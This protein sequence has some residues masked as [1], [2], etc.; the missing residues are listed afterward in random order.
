MNVMGWCAE[1]KVTGQRVN[2]QS[3][4]RLRDELFELI[5]GNNCEWKSENKDKKRI[6]FIFGEKWKDTRVKVDGYE[7]N[8]LRMLTGCEST[9][10]GCNDGEYVVIFSFF[11]RNLNKKDYVNK[12]VRKEENEP[13]LKA[14]KS[15]KKEDVKEVLRGYVK[16]LKRLWKQSVKNIEGIDEPLEPQTVD[17]FTIVIGKTE[18]YFCRY[19]KIEKEKKKNDMATVIKDIIEDLIKNKKDEIKNNDVNDVVVLFKTS[20]DIIVLS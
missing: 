20:N 7:I 14:L 12:V 4:R 6:E 17:I 2:K 13:E 3:R 16:I 9:F 10:I 5:K 1:E 15:E 19:Q 18:D 8:N 11:N